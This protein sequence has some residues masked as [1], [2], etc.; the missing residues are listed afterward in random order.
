MKMMINE[1]HEI[2]VDAEVLYGVQ[3]LI[4]DVIMMIALEDILQKPL[5]MKISMKYETGTIELTNFIQ[6]IFWEQVYLYL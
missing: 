5:L 6:K 3:E 2:K 1:I 4:M